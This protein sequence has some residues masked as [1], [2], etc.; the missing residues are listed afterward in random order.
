M[1]EK[2]K[3]KGKRKIEKKEKKKKKR[4]RKR[5]RKRKE[6]ISGLAN[7]SEYCVCHI[8]ER[9]LTPKMR[10]EQD[11]APIAIRLAAGTAAPNETTTAH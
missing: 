8:L 10:A 2:L 11:G 4:K 1:K 6:K 9:R 3:V 7:Q 5:K